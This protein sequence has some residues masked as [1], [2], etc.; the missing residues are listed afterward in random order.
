M[1]VTNHCHRGRMC[2]FSHTKE[3]QMY[4][5]LVYKTQ[6]CRDWPS[7]N[8]HFC[9]FSHGLCELRNPDSLDFRCIQ[10]PE[11]L[12]K[13]IR[14]LTFGKE[15]AENNHEEGGSD[16]VC[17]PGHLTTEKRRSGS[18]N[19][20][21]RADMSCYTSPTNCSSQHSN[22][23]RMDFPR[24]PTTGRRPRR[25]STSNS[26]CRY[27]PSSSLTGRTPSNG[28]KQGYT[29]GPLTEYRTSE[30]RKLML[31]SDGVYLS[32][33]G[34]SAKTPVSSPQADDIQTDISTYVQALFSALGLDSGN[35]IN[36]PDF[37]QQACQAVLSSSDK[38]GF[39]PKSLPPSAIDGICGVPWKF[40]EVDEEDDV[41]TP[42]TPR[43]V[44]PIVSSQNTTTNTFDNS[45]FFTPW[46]RNRPG[47]IDKGGDDDSVGSQFSFL[48][49]AD[50]ER[51]GVLNDIGAGAADFWPLRNAKWTPSD[52]LPP[53]IAPVSAEGGRGRRGSGV[54]N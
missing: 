43:S 23:N 51:G 13:P 31:G 6:L 38:F 4:H 25:P 15:F 11:L 28:E 2:M 19:S 5:P 42:S 54:R 50:G 22:N 10:G 48:E 24:T 12:E 7:C 32:L 16:D 27:S 9:P 41:S 1:R 35:S 53:G 17:F 36:P 20:S 18:T 30:G 47:V 26:S 44:S 46:E 40:G 33:N 29:R 37:Q 34:E 39:C 8:K 14:L 21:L 52:R 49:C 45:Y 3:E